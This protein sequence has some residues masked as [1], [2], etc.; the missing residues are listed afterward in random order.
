MQVKMVNVFYCRVGFCRG[1]MK[2]S[3]G[4]L[5]VIIIISINCK[6]QPVNPSQNNPESKLAV[7]KKCWRGRELKLPFFC[8]G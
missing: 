6:Q 8:C 5:L 4:V 3:G 1:K 7:E 2:S